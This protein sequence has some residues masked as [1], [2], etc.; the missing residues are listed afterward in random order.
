MS[1]PYASMTLVKQPCRKLFK[2]WE[3]CLAIV[4]FCP[5]KEHPEL[6]MLVEA[7]NTSEEAIPHWTLN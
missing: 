2:L 7:I 3:N 5:P 1:S 6:W 4:P